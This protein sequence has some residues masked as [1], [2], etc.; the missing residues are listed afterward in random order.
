M[1]INIMTVQVKKKSWPVTTVNVFLLP[2]EDCLILLN[3]NNVVTGRLYQSVTWLA[4][5]EC[6]TC[7]RMYL[8]SLEEG[9]PV[10]AIGRQPLYS[11]NELADTQNDEQHVTVFIL[12]L[13]CY[14][15]KYN[16][17]IRHYCKYSTRNLKLLNK[18]FMIPLFYN[19]LNLLHSDYFLIVQKFMIINFFLTTIF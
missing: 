14:A 5:Q 12:P 4:S 15:Q 16:D 13:P 17:N 19:P 18:F 10:T 1:S 2:R 9:K 7:I 8:I 11:F 3:S 6:T